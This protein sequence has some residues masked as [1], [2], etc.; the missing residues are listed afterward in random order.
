V[1]KT[2]K[3]GTRRRDIEK[4]DFWNDAKWAIPVFVAIFLFMLTYLLKPVI[5]NRFEIKELKNKLEAQQRELN[6]LKQNRDIMEILV[7][8]WLH[9]PSDPCT[10]N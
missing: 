10:G 6:G 8:S 4:A 2:R 1:G 5:E 7:N 3:K 9:S